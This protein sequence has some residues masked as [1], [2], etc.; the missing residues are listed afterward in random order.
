MPV[1]LRDCKLE[2][3]GYRFFFVERRE[4]DFHF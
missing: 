2:N 3:L 4:E 1:A